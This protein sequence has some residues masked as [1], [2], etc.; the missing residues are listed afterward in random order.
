MKPQTIQDIPKPALVTGLLGLL[1]FISLG[2]IIVDQAPDVRGEILAALLAYGAVILSFLGGVRWG[3]A[4]SG[5][6]QA[7]LT[8]QLCISVIP[9]LVGWVAIL[10]EKQAGLLVLTV[11][12]SLMLLIDFLVPGAPAWY[13]PLRMLLSITVMACLLIVLLVQ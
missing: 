3:V 8:S 9:S 1:P 5:S 13:L 6:S 7:P 11:A 4:I 10:I 2:A 12:F